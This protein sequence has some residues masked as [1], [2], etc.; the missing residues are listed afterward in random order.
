MTDVYC[1][2]VLQKVTSHEYQIKLTIIRFTSLVS[3]LLKNVKN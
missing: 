1:V 2:I 3:F